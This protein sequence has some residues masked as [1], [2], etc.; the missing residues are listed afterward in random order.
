MEHDSDADADAIRSCAYS[1][2]SITK[3]MCFCDPDDVTGG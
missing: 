1:L 2:L 3:C